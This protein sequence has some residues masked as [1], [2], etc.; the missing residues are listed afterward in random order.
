MLEA[1]RLGLASI[2]LLAGGLITLA[3]GYY[4]WLGIRHPGEQTPSLGPLIGG[5]AGVAG[6]SLAPIGSFSDR[7]PYLWIPLVLD[8]GTGLYFGMVFTAVVGVIVRK[9]GE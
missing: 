5:I 8:L 6:L 9:D 7:L 3:N 1:V 2:L 4:F